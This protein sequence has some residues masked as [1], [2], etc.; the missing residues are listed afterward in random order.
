MTGDNDELCFDPPVHADMARD[1]PQSLADRSAAAARLMGS[2][3]QWSDRA[4]AT[5]TGLAS[6]TV[7]A[8]RLRTGASA[9]RPVR[10]GLD[11]KVRPLSSAEGRRTASA[12]VAEN[13][14]ASLRAIA[15][16][17]GI[18]LGT[19]RDVRERLRRGEDPLLPWQRAAEDRAG[20]TV[21]RVAPTGRQVVVTRPVRRTELRVLRNDPSL[22]YLVGGRVLLR[23]LDTHIMDPEEWKRLAELVPA[24]CA[25]M[26]SEAA[27]EC[28]GI[29]QDFADAVDRRRRVNGCR[30]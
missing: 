9:S 4:I 1:I 30:S 25:G 21:R 14:G 27:R 12:Y 10:V 28:A 15:K 16:A 13:P 20:G 26:V 18:S 24:H 6:K 7:A 29:W 3:P 17:A 22:R 8:I 23:L 2:H 5:A 11:G 19:A